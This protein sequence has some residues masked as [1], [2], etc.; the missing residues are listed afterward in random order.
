MALTPVSAMTP[1]KVAEPAVL[2]VLAVWLSTPSVSE[3]SPP[4][5]PTVTSPAPVRASTRT[6]PST[7]AKRAP[8][9]TFRSARLFVQTSL[10]LLLPVKMPSWTSMSAPEPSAK[11]ATEEPQV[12][13]PAPAFTNVPVPRKVAVA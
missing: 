7:A 11:V 2:K 9:A 6:F 4:A 12:A 1:E 10:L 13:R 5:K 3:P 8:E